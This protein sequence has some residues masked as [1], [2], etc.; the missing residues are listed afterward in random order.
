MKMKM[1]SLSVSLG[2]LLFAQEFRATVS[3]RIVDPSGAGVSGAKIEV[4]SVDTRA[5]ANVVSAEDGS[6]QVSFL[7]PGMYSV[8]VEKTGF[9]RVV[10]EGVKLGVSEKAV[11]DIQLML[12]AVNQSVNEIGRASCRER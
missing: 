5:I 8:T 10:R 9:H 4:V 7:N 1:A 11:V 12:G 6:Y 2:A 3:G